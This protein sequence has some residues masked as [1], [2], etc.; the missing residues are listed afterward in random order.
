[1][2]SIS[3]G[4]PAFSERFRFIEPLLPPLEAVLEEYRDAYARGL[5][6]NAGIVA[7]FESAAAEYLE[8]GHCVAVASC[9]S[10]LMM[11]MKALGLT[12]EVILPSF[13][14]FATGHAARWN[15]LRPVF[16]DCDPETFNLDPAD[17]E[18]RITPRT[19][20]VVAVHM[21]GNP[22]D[23]DALELLAARHGLKLII[24]AAH[25][26]GSRTRGRP[27]GGFG[28]AEVFSLSP[29]KLLV[30]GEGGLVATNDASLA[31]TL[32]A[33]RNY[34]DTGAYDPDWLGMSARMSEFN[35]ALALAGIPMVDAKVERR[36]RI[37]EM[38]TSGLKGLPGLR[39]Q[40]IRAG[41]RCTVK[42]YSVHV[43]PEEFGMTRDD[44]AAELL[45]ENVE[46]KKYFYPPLHQQ[47]LYR[48]FYSRAEAPLEKTEWVANGVL[49]L[50]VY[51]ALADETVTRITEVIAR[52]ASRADGRRAGELRRGAGELL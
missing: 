1:M 5:I 29:T 43:T 11:T 7:Q 18:R 39:F 23:V 32:R 44:L 24:D 6:T 50:P 46:T 2:N 42:D 28:N 41:D 16:A 49:S 10:G 37:A 22:C 9:T 20:A 4:Q 12:G 19:S 30:A 35:A 27:V 21:Y 25:A 14:F 17:V 45:L 52:I 34:G 8:V 15:G 13:T 48:A 3:G 33:M 26:F 40:K 36:N 31:R 51:E 38:Y 47:K